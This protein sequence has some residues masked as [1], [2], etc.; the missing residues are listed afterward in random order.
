[1]ACI[2]QKLQKCKSIISI[3]INY[4]LPGHTYMPVDSM[5]AVIEKSVENT[6]IW[7][8]SQWATVFS[9]ARKSQKPYDVTSLT[10]KD[11]E[12]WDAV[13]EKYFKGNLIG[14]ISKIRT[15]IVKKS[16]SD[17]MFVKYSMAADTETDVI[18][19]SGKKEI[20]LK[21]TYKSQ[22]PISK[23]I[24]DDLLRLCTNKTIPEMYH[25][26]FKN[27]PTAANVQDVL[28]ESDIEDEN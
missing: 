28:P 11:F 27:L 23:K 17:K 4:L 21:K 13:A 2:H 14:K 8:P 16:H 7:A 3:Q 24:Y 26:E 12:A 1:M 5:H 6:I 9:L 25:S 22:L 10:Y 19:I 15:A 20:N 18:E